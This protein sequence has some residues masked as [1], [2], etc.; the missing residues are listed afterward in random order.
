MNT[1]AYN[2]ED[3][4]IPQITECLLLSCV[5]SFEDW[6]WIFRTRSFTLCKNDLDFTERSD[7]VTVSESTS[8]HHNKS[9]CVLCEPTGWLFIYRSP[10][11]CFHHFI[12]FPLLRRPFFVSIPLWEVWWASAHHRSH[13]S[14]LLLIPRLRGVWLSNLVFPGLSDA[15][16]ASTSG[17]LSL[18]RE[19][20]F[21]IGFD[22]AVTRSSP[23][24]FCVLFD[25][26][27]E[28]SVEL[29]WLMLNKHKRWSHSSRVK[30]PLVNMSASWFLVSMYLIWILE[31]KLIRS[32]DQSIATLWVLETRLNVG[33]LPFMIIL[34]TASLSSNTYNKASWW[35]DWTFEGINQR[36]PNH[37]SLHE[38]SFIFELCEVLNEPHFGS[39]TSL[40]V[41]SWFWVVFSKN[42]LQSEPI[43]QE[44][45]YYPTSILHPK[46]WFLIL[47]NCVKLTF[48]S[49]TSNLLE[50]MYDF[51]KH[52]MFHPK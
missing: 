7:S 38:I 25:I 13:R 41:Q 15:V 14:W 9:V 3:M 12:R 47:L 29:K 8:S 18:H 49:C 19:T 52:T 24:S 45:E 32:N 4:N 26:T 33:L 48:V 2:V 31:S 44:R 11:S 34:I 16:E 20:K 35:E 10:R 1:D 23:A 21:I 51:Q 40:S 43:D 27:S 6:S 36:C 37:W 46:K 5:A 28:Q 22:F 17:S 30:F 42:F 50:Q 39:Y